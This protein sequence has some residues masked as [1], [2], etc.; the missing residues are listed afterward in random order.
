MGEE[1]ETKQGTSQRK[2]KKPQ[3]TSVK[4]ADALFVHSCIDNGLIQT[5][6]M[7]PEDFQ[8]FM[9][10]TIFLEDL[11]DEY[12]KMR[13]KRMEDYEVEKDENGNFK[14]EDHPKKKEI[15]NVIEEMHEQEVEVTP[16]KFMDETSFY[17]ATKKSNNLK[18]A[19]KI[20]KIVV[21]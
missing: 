10:L 4:R 13:N 21:K 14:I 16:A 18:A 6:E 3:T 8:N 19:A 17:K 9:R 20:R 1:K 12:I 5:Q 2:S 11:R 15:E 7:G